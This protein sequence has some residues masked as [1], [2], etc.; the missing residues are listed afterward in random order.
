MKLSYFF[1]NYVRDQVD[2]SALH[3]LG[4]SLEGMGFW[5]IDAVDHI[6]YPWPQGENRRGLPAAGV[7]GPTQAPVEPL[8]Y[9]AALAPLTSRIRL[10]TSIIILP[11]REPVLVAKQGASIDQLSGGRFELGVGAGWLQAEFEALGATF[12]N[13]G[14]RMDEA[15]EVI[16]RCWTD[17]HVSFSGRFYQVDDMSVAPKPR[18]RPHPPIW[19]GGGREN[20]EPVMRRLG[21]FADGWMIIGPGERSHVER[22]IELAKLEAQRCGRGELDFLLQIVLD[23]AGPDWRRTAEQRLRHFE[24]IGITVLC[25]NTISDPA[26]RTTADHLGRLREYL[27]EFGLPASSQAGSVSDG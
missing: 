17:E 21:R 24:E 16:R 9:L 11:Q 13:R 18:Q 20:L 6:T 12:G 22:G 1:P 23:L 15:M 10:R 3:E 4:Q 5:G 14:R 27:T 2:A 25:L 7:H 19:I 8:A 26:L